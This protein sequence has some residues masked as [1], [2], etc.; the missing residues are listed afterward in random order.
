MEELAAIAP[1]APA[2]ELWGKVVV[3]GKPRGGQDTGVRPE[4]I[5]VSAFASQWILIVPGQV[6][7]NGEPISEPG[8]G[9]ENP[10]A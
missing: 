1:A 9:Y 5:R 6:I 3:A 2:R 10:S 7:E 8:A 4:P